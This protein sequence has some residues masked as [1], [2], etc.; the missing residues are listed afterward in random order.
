MSIPQ[1]VLIEALEMQD[2]KIAFERVVETL[3]TVEKAVTNFES[4]WLAVE[5]ANKM[6]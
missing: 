5:L 2:Q 6:V 3:G 1:N 4:K